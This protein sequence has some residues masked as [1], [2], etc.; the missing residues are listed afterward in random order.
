M[1]IKQERNLTIMVGEK[2]K[3][4]KKKTSL[5]CKIEIKT[6]QTKICL[7]IKKKTNGKHITQEEK[8]VI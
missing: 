6:K 1:E 8:K 3:K 4:K 5:T 7:G 2:K